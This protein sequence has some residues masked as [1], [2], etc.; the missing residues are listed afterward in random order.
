M[1]E[2]SLFHDIYAAAPDEGLGDDSDDD[3]GIILK[4]ESAEVDVSTAA[5]VLPERPPARRYRVDD[6]DLGCATDPRTTNEV[7]GSAEMGR[8]D[9]AA[10]KQRL[11]NT[12]YTALVQRTV[13]RQRLRDSWNKVGGYAIF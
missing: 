11:Y 12:R 7:I 1:E 6:D 8:D 13:V 5:R 2:P 10:M 9:D 4:R 3:V